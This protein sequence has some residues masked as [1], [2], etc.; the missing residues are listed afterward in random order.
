MNKEQLIKNLKSP[1]GKIDVILDTDT[2]NEIDDQFALA[3]LL[4]NRERLNP[5]GFCAAPFLNKRSSS[6]ADGML[7]SYDEIFKVLDLCDR[8][9]LKNIVY[10]GS[11][12]YLP[13]ERT[14]VQSDAARFMADISNNYSPEKPL[15]IVAIG[16]S[17]NVASAL[18]INPQMKENTVIVWLAGK[19]HH[20]EE[21]EEFNL[22]QDYAAAR[23]IMKS[24]VPFVQLPCAGVV[25]EFYTGKDELNRFYVGKNRLATYLAENTIDFCSWAGDGYPWSKVIWDV[26]AVAWLLNDNGRFMADRIQETRLPNWGNFYEEP[27]DGT[28]MTYV[29]R[30]RRDAL[31]AD[32]TEKITGV[33]LR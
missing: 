8:S 33:R 15:Y 30:I 10:K 11:E 17:T 29:Y 16:A 20:M 13:D 25:S 28:A 31:F 1:S 4:R 5:V 21:C 3:Y 12:N 19:A 23:V 26:T 22:S 27:L 24:G 18:L 7:K 14:P 6:P 2:Y 9:D 32:M